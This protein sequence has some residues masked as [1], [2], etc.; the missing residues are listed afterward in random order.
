MTRKPVKPAL[1]QRV[2]VTLRALAAIVGGY[3]MA[4]ASTAFLARV[5]PLSRVEATNAAMLCSFLIFVAVA[6]WAFAAR[7]VARVWAII[8]PLAGGMVLFVQLG[9]GAHTP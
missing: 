7:S 3:G 8:L 4:A 6:L 2:D 9:Q 5:L 1:R